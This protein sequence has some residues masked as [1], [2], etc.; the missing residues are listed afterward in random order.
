M[1]KSCQV[2]KRFWEAIEEIRR[3]RIELKKDKV[4]APISYEKVTNLLTRHALWKEI[5][6]G[7]IDANDEEVKQF[8]IT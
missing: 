6:K 1:K 2:G 5:S 4:N 8:G 3:K 7:I